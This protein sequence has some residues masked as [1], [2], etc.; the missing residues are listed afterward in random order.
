MR[1]RLWTFLC[2]DRA[3]SVS[4]EAIWAALFMVAFFAPTAFLYRY[5]ESH[6]EASF[7]QRTAA[8]NEAVNANCSGNYFLPLPG[9]AKKDPNSVT[10]INCSKKDGEGANEKF[11]TAMDRV[12]TKF[13][14][15]LNDLKKHGKIEVVNGGSS[16]A[17]RNISLGQGGPLSFLDAAPT[18]NQSS[19]LIP[20]TEYWLFDQ[21]HWARG[22][23]RVVWQKFSTK[24]RKLFP[25]VY[26][27]R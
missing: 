23:D 4:F 13:P 20:T 14:T 18:L 25:N 2:D 11:W 5:S 15:L 26:P 8:R 10:I 27:S 22:H 24:Q 9:S 7:A 19:I 16:V 1:N 17:S 21:T 12:S 3:G 6:L